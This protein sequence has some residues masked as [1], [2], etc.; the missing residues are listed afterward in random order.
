MSL[1]SIY[2]KC[3]Q[4]LPA[5]E[6]AT[7]KDLHQE[8]FQALLTE[9]SCLREEA[10][11]DDTHQIQ[12][13]TVTFS[14]LI[15]LVS[16][17]AAFHD[18]IPHRVT[19]FLSFIALPCLTMFMG[20]LWIDLIYRR[21]RFGAYTKVLENKI[22][23]VLSGKRPSV[24]PAE[25]RVLDWE[26]WIQRLEDDKGFFNVTRFFRGYIVSGSW[27][28]AP[29]LIMGSYFLLADQPLSIEWARVKGLCRTYWFPALLMAAVYLVYYV[30][31]LKFLL[32]IKHFPKEVE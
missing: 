32:R 22:N 4:P 1:F 10:Q 12:L 17:A 7:E 13:V 28:V 27:L 25:E 8:T 19:L 30:F 14:T 21:T 3:G 9:Y 5:P 20:L 18:A 11:H 29:L 31:F 26:H 2:C 24:S 15:T 23:N 16:A 6:K